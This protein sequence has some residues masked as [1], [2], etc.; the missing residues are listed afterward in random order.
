MNRYL[1]AST[2]ACHGLRPQQGFRQLELKFL[3]ELNLHWMSPARHGGSVKV[4]NNQ[5]RRH[6]QSLVQQGFATVQGGSKKRQQKYRLTRAGLLYELRCIYELP[7]VP[8]EDF[9]FIF[10]FSKRYHMK[11]HQLVRASGFE[12]PKALELEIESLMNPKHLLYTQLR[13]LEKELKTIEDHI[14]RVS[15]AAKMSLKLR[16]QRHSPTEIAKA[17]EA[18]YPYDFNALKKIS[19]LYLDLPTD[20]QLDEMIAGNAD[21]A[22]ILWEPIKGS[23]LQHRENIKQLQ[24]ELIKK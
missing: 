21:R 20:L 23:L 5:V 4:H 24:K 18:H 6:L 17:I 13:I 15:G 11:I 14:S 7:C 9:Y 3:L 19:D 12:L 2:I 10:Y 8:T 22:S 16:K 1:S